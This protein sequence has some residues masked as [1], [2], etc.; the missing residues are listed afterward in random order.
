[1]VVIFVTVMVV[2]TPGIVTMVVMSGI[3]VVVM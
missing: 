1:M 3:I 2:V